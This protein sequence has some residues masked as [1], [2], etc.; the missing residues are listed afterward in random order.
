MSNDGGARETQQSSTSWLKRIIG[1]GSPKEN[2][3]YSEEL[4]KKLIGV[5]RDVHLWTI[6]TSSTSIPRGGKSHLPDTPII[7]RAYHKI[8]KT[9]S[10]LIGVGVL[11]GEDVY[12]KRDPNDRYEGDATQKK[13]YERGNDSIIIPNSFFTEGAF[14]VVL[15]PNYHPID[16]NNTLPEPQ[17]TG[18][19][20][21]VLQLRGKDIIKLT[22][23]KKWLNETHEV[24]FP[25]EPDLISMQIDPSDKNGSAV[26]QYEGFLTTRDLFVQSPRDAKGRTQPTLESTEAQ[27]KRTVNGTVCYRL[28]EGNAQRKESKEPKSSAVPAPLRVRI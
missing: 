11:R 27:Y 10:E 2:R 19:G 14:V 7:P 5:E 28:V 13:R 16:P 21:T 26:V 6:D 8:E 3:N 1:T 24:T 18:Y 25:N 15:V 20:V 22:T 23:D 9:G 4:K 17:L 12:A